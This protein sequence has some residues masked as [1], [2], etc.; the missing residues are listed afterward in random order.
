MSQSGNSS[1]DHESSPLDA[2]A[3]IES[4]IDSNN[5]LAQSFRGIFAN[6]DAPTNELLLYGILLYP[7]E[8]WPDEGT[9][10]FVDETPTESDCLKP[11]HYA[12][13]P[14]SQRRS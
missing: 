1:H 2:L 3:E 6:E 9:L 10:V 5:S 12:S 13:F 4:I 7:E 8:P 14:F 11:S